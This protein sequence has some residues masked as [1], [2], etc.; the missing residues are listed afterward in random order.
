MTELTPS[1]AGAGLAWPAGCLPVAGVLGAAAAVTGAARPDAPGGG[2][3]AAAGL[4]GGA[5][6]AAGLA[7]AGA[8]GS[9]AVA[10]TGAAGVAA[11]GGEAA[12]GCAGLGAALAAGFRA[13]LKPCSMTSLDDFANGAAAAV[14]AAVVAASATAAA[15]DLAAA[16]GKA[17]RCAGA[18]AGGSVEITVSGRLEGGCGRGATGC[19]VKAVKSSSSISASISLIRLDIAAGASAAGFGWGGALRPAAGDLPP[20]F[21]AAS[22]LADSALDGLVG[23]L[24]F[25]LKIENATVRKISWGHAASNAPD[26]APPNPARWALRCGTNVPLLWDQFTASASANSTLNTVP[27][28]SAPSRICTRARWPAAISRTMARPRPEPSAL[29]S[30][31]LL[32]R[33]R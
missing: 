32:P 6:G 22:G 3:V 9:C 14:A 15:A 20:G 31:A 25:L 29:A 30:L 16:A 27:C 11:A 33:T 5:A 1:A 2:G 10:C 7:R 17:A 13:G 21:A 8:A 18:S 19:A 4:A 12:T 28:P 24:P 23:S 26:T